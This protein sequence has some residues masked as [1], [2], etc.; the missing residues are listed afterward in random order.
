MF[1]EEPSALRLRASQNK[2]EREFDCRLSCFLS[3]NT[4]NISFIYMILIISILSAEY[5]KNVLFALN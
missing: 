5:N 2:L 1:S 4:R 3:V